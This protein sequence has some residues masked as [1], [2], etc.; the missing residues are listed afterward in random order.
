MRHY[1]VF[2]YLTI[3]LL[4][5]ACKKD[6]INPRNPEVNPLLSVLLNSQYMPAAKI[7]SAIAIWEINGKAQ[8]QSL[9]FS[10]DTLIARLLKFSQGD[11][12]LTIQLYTKTRVRDK[13]LQWEKRVN[14]NVKHNES[15]N[16]SGPS[17]LQ[18]I[19]WFP[20]VILIDQATGFTAIVALNPNDPYFLLKNI[21]ARWNKF[22]VE[23]GYYKIPGGAESVGKGY[24]KCTSCADVTGTVENRE[25]FMSL[26]G[27]INNR[28]W[29]M[30]EIGVGLFNNT[31]NP[32]PGFYFNHY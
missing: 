21:P 8:K 25:F 11:G 17:G 10:G 6:N 27:Q 16:I 18:E 19:S 4:V 24:W 5:T 32:G 26:P 28:P 31:T 1:I 9:H 30:V 12:Q 23:R 22:E 7:D 13:N 29:R 14:I 15:I 2:T 3:M 20:R